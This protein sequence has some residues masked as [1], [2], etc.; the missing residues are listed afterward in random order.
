MSASLSSPAL[1]DTDR[2]GQTARLIAGTFVLGLYQ[3]PPLR[4]V[5][6]QDTIVQVL[7]DFVGLRVLKLAQI[8]P[9]CSKSA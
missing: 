3:A 8:I 2:N 5:G 1:L 6:T 4:P 7:E 9:P